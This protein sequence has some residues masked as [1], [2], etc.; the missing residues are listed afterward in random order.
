VIWGFDGGKLVKGRKRHVGTDT[1]GLL[2]GLVV[3]EANLNDREGARLVAAQLV[4][5]SPRLARFF[6][7]QGFSGEELAAWL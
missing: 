5:R 6:A 4:G 3:T 2:H 1:L 7:D